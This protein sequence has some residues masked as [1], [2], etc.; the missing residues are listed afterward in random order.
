MPLPEPYQY[1]SSGYTIHLYCRNADCPVYRGDG[2]QDEAFGEGPHAYHEARTMARKKGW[3]LH[4]DNSATCPT[5]Q[6]KNND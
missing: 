2:P 4:K 5:C 1:I 3:I 6:G